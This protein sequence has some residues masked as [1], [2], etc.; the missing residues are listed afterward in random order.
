[1]DNKPVAIADSPLEIRPPSALQ[2]EEFDF[3]YIASAAGLEDIYNQLLDMS[4]PKHKIIRVYAENKLCFDEVCVPARIRFL[5]QFAEYACEQGI[6]GSVAE[7]GVFRGDFAKE[8]NRVFPDRKLY[9]FDTFEGFSDR[10][11]KVESEANPTYGDWQRWAADVNMLSDTSVKTVTDR[12][13]HPQNAHIR[14]GFFPDTFDVV[15]EQFA[16]VNLDMDLYAPTK[17]GLELFYPKMSRGGLILIHDYFALGGV[18]N[19]AVDEFLRQNGLV[20][21]P[22]GD[23]VSFAIVKK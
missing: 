11:L 8:I 13:P 19:D 23:G 17:A 5:E 9:L 21:M 14:K 7:C 12:L 10:D 4:V 22:I 3:V 20:G 15:D 2:R 6:A 1:V 16:F 18:V